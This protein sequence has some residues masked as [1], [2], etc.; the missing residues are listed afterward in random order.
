MVTAMCADFI[1][2]T[3]VSCCTEVAALL[4]RK[5]NKVCSLLFHSFL[6]PRYKTISLSDV[7]SLNI[8]RKLYTM[9]PNKLYTMCPNKL[10]TMC[11]NKLYTM[12]PVYTVPGVP[13]NYKL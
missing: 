2:I 11:P 6:F 7:F 1:M 3:K 9:C 5:E 13:K 8:I 10:Y 4:L 12:L